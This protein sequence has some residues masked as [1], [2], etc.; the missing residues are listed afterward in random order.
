MPPLVCTKNKIANV[1]IIIPVI[2]ANKITKGVL[3]PIIYFFYYKIYV[4]E[5]ILF[6]IILFVIILLSACTQ[7]PSGTLKVCERPEMIK[8]EDYVVSNVDVKSGYSTQIKFVVRNYCSIQIK[9]LN[10]KVFD[11]H[12]FNV[13]EIV[14][15]Y[16]SSKNNNEI[17]LSLPPYGFAFCTISLKAKEGITA[18]IPS[19]IGFYYSFSAQNTKSVVIPIIDGK[20]YT[21]PPQPYKESYEDYGYLNLEFYPPVGS[22]KKE[23]DRIIKEY[24]GVV[25]QP[26]RIEMQLVPRGIGVGTSDFE[27]KNII[28]KINDDSLNI[29]QS[30]CDFDNSLNLKD[31]VI[32]KINSGLKTKD[33]TKITCELQYNT[34]E[35]PIAYPSIDFIIDYEARIYKYENFVVVPA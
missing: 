24:W 15:G 18:V 29:I 8:I 3:T 30:A 12:L 17:S 2:N 6:S 1:T 10:I 32:S 28:M 13:E 5:K 11:P 21:R 34:K 7:T 20:I 25:G 23:G 35:T 14:C 33:Y 16:S 22:I 9:N 27:L 26:F 4:M 19:T 31:D